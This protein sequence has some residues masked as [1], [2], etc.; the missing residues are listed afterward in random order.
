MILERKA[1]KKQGRKTREG[2]DFVTILV[3]VCFLSFSLVSAIRVA[4]T[5]KSSL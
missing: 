5:S 4:I 3:L 1:G 2:K